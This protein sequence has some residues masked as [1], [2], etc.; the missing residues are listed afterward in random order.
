MSVCGIDLGTCNSC[1][2]IVT[3]SGPQIVRDKYNRATVP[4]VV[5]CDARG[6]LVVGHAAKSRLGQ[7]PS[8]VITVKR[9]MGTD[10]KVRLGSGLKS[11]VEISAIILKHLKGLGEEASGTALDKVVVTVPAYFNF[12]QK[13]DTEIAAREA[14]FA[15]VEILQEPVAAA[16]AYCIGAGDE[17]M[18]LL[19]YDLGGGTFD[20]TVLERTAD[21]EIDVLA[22]GGDKWLGG[23][24]FDSLLAEHL[25]CSLKVRGYSVDWDLTNP[26]QYAK[27]QKLKD[28]AEDTKKRLG[29]SPEVTIAYPQVFADEDG[30]LVDLDE[31]ITQETFYSLIGERIEHSVTLTRETLERSRIPI[32]RI[33]KLIMVG[34]SSYL[35]RVQ[36]RLAETFGIKPELVDP[37]TI[38]AVGAAI[39]AAH[40][41]GRRHTGDGIAVDLTYDEHTAQRTA[42]IRARLSRTVAGW[43]ARLLADEEESAQ[44]VDGERFHFEQVSLREAVANEFTLIL[45][46]EAG[47]ERLSTIIEIIHD[48]AAAAVLPPDAMIAKPISIRTMGGLEQMIAAGTK[49]PATVRR[50]FATEDQSGRIRI[51][52]YEGTVEIGQVVLADVP[53]DLATGSE[54]DV[55]LAF[56]KNYSVS[57]SARLRSTGQ[58]AL[59]EFQIPQ[60]RVPS[61]S[62]AKA[63]LAKFEARWTEGEQK[64]GRCD[65]E[66]FRRIRSQVAAELT[67]PEPK[68]AKV[69]EDLSEL[70]ALLIAMETDLVAIATLRPPRAEVLSRLNEVTERARQRGAGNGFDRDV[71]IGRAAR[72][73]ERMAGCW[74]A[75][76]II[77]W[78]D[79]VNSVKAL[80]AV[81]APRIEDMSEDE[82]RRLAFFIA[83]EIDS[84]LA[85]DGR[86]RGLIGGVT[87]AKLR[88]LAIQNAHDAFHQALDCFATL[89]NAGVIAFPE[90]STDTAPGSMPPLA[91]LIGLVR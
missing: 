71:V 56:A 53:K 25:R 32:D 55:D 1:I 90:T 21:N 35:P 47:E 18:I 12:R 78:Q 11:P 46:D 8:P 19:A 68:L 73:E 34:G 76:D 74:A 82:A 85:A 58:S 22:F 39:K 49:L 83:S 87:P 81:V 5:H 67:A 27:F 66:A 48:V 7:V 54:V 75:R 59:V 43:T 41:F 79:V 88:L 60:I 29:T 31:V 24:D 89:V 51:P 14:G 70:D 77:G 61:M 33:A 57:A 45:E 38:V 84:L 28:L 62:D 6:K 36:Q 37:E 15:E 52:I 64:G 65:A 50:C 42:S 2:V 63:R 30:V 26:A 69:A 9:K 4:S 80:E 3:A 44:Q 17:P 23:D 91:A 13:Q 72:V 10:E 20:V 40:C 86:V 16:L